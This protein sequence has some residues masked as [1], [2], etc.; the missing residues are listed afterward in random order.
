[1]PIRIPHHP[2][3]PAN[4]WE[5]C[6][7][8]IG[9]EKRACIRELTFHLSLSSIHWYVL[10]GAT[11][12]IGRSKK[13]NAGFALPERR[14]RSLGVSCLCVRPGG[15]PPPLF[16]SQCRDRIDLQRPKRRNVDRDRRGNHQQLWDGEYRRTHRARAEY[17][18]ANQPRQ[19]VR[20]KSFRPTGRRAR[21]TCRGGRAS[22]TPF[23]AAPSAMRM[24]ISCV[25]PDTT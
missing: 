19:A 20:R 23:R 16:L 25:W 21:S 13:S 2:R 17:H 10:P 3:Y 6:T 4:L 7:D 12:P 5:S 1:M 14:S 18:G 22:R 15:R 8:E 11:P 24:P 9:N